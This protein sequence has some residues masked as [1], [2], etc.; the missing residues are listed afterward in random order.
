METTIIKEIKELQNYLLELPYGMKI[1]NGEKTLTPSWFEFSRTVDK[2]IAKLMEL[3]RQNS[4]L[5]TKNDIDYIRSIRENDVIRAL[6]DKECHKNVF[7]RCGCD[8]E[9]LRIS[10]SIILIT[11]RF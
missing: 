10:N 5:I 8:E 7:E 11:N 4:T 1:R 9:M 3:C 6:V 2:I